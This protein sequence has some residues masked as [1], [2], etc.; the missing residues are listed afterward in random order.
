MEVT[1]AFLKMAGSGPMKFHGSIASFL[2]FPILL[3]LLKPRLENE[4]IENDADKIIDKIGL[5]PGAVWMGKF[6]T[7]CVFSWL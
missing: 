4:K 6:G 3:L 5:F 7:K 2:T 1:W